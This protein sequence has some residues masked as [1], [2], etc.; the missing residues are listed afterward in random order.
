MPE[1]KDENGN[2]HSCYCKKRRIEGIKDIELKDKETQVNMD[3]NERTSKCGKDSQSHSGLSEP[4]VWDRLGPATTR[5]AIRS[6]DKE[7]QVNL[8]DGMNFT[9]QEGFTQVYT[10]GACYHGGKPWARAGYG[11]W[12]GDQHR[13]NRSERLPPTSLQDSTVAE[14]KA[15]RVAIEQ[16]VEH[17]VHKLQVGLDLRPTLNPSASS[18]T[19][20]LI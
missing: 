11:V 6:E 15:A 12:W 13:L 18:T 20:V 17:S 10:D 7:T 3:E 14:I 19:T 9:V 2:L 5:P 4:S 16:A 1:E 8:D